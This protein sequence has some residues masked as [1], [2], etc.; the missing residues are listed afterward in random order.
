MWTENF[1]AEHEEPVTLTWFVAEE[2]YDKVWNPEKNV[3]DGK[4]LK[5][6]GVNLEI[7]AGDLT[8]LDALIATDSLPD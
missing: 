2:G 3:A 5:N 4:I 7:K 6:T 8:D 1:Q